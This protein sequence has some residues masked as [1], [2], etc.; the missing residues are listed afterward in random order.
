MPNEILFTPAIKSS[1]TFVGVTSLGF[2][3]KVISVPESDNLFLTAS[4]ISLI[5]LD[6]VNEGVP[7]PKYILLK[8]L[9]SIK[10]S[11]WLI[12]FITAFANL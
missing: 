1:L 12:S 3:S 6:E 7:P 8:L 10:F 9:F 11:D 2:I 5:D 4:K